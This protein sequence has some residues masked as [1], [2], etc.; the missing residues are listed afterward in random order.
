MHGNQLLFEPWAHLEDVGG[1][2]DEEETESQK[3]RRLQI[4]PCSSIPFAQD[5][6]EDDYES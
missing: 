6:D 5:G 2:Q 1:I 3:I 4:F